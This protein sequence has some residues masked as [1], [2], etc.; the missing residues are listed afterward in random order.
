MVFFERSG[1]IVLCFWFVNMVSLLKTILLSVSEE[2]LSIVFFLFNRVAH[3]L[4][5]ILITKKIPSFFIMII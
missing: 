3:E 4:N 5:V 1:L 2:I